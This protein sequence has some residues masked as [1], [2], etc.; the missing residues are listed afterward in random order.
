MIEL[1]NINE[2]DCII[3]GIQLYGSKS[4]PFIVR[5]TKDITFNYDNFKNNVIND[6]T[7]IYSTDKITL[8]YVEDIKLLNT[9][10]DWE[11]NIMQYNFTDSTIKPNLFDYNMINVDELKKYG[12]GL[13]MCTDNTYT[14]FHIDSVSSKLGG[15]GWV[16]LNKG[17]K[18]WNLIEFFDAV[19]NIYNSKD[20]CMIDINIH[21]ILLQEDISYKVYQGTINSGDFIYFPPGWAHQ[22]TTTEKSIGLN[23]YMRLDSDLQY[24]EKIED[25]YKINNNYP[26]CGLLH[27]P[28]KENEIDL[29]RKINNI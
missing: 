18:Q 2:V 6:N 9:L 4:K 7:I 10:N 5:N 20:K 8:E 22:I 25:W 1:I 16:Y 24:V 26:D 11:N 28:L 13:T 17:C 14:P 21:N 27:R 29:H 15:G 12:V 23:G 3:N 19:N